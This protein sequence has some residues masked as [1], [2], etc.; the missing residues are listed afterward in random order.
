MI[1]KNLYHTGYECIEYFVKITDTDIQ[2]LCYKKSTK[3][4]K[5]IPIG[6]QNLIRSFIDYF[7]YIIYDNY[8]IGDDWIKITNDD[9]NDLCMKYYYNF[10]SL[11]EAGIVNNRPTLP[12][13]S[14]M[15][16]SQVNNLKRPIEW[17]PD[18][19]KFD[20]VTPFFNDTKSVNNENKCIIPAHGIII[21]KDQ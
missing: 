12:T 19:P 4:L 9:F 7:E 11:S 21:N 10:R 18:P 20:M 14:Y 15:W 6:H 8:P 3:E 16:H 17:N 2:N 5:S 13:S 1:H